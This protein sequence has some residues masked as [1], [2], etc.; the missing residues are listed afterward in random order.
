YGL[1]IYCSPDPGTALD[2]ATPFRHEGTR[3]RAVLQCF[4][5]PQKKKLGKPANDAVRAD[6]EYW[7]VPGGHAIRPYAICLFEEP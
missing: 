1:G 4:V 3:Y 5:D 2:Y 6:G 7:V